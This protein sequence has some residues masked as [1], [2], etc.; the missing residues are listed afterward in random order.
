MT[1]LVKPGDVGSPIYYLFVRDSGAADVTNLVGVSAGN[2]IY[3]G[4]N[5]SQVLQLVST[6]GGNGQAIFILRGLGEGTTEVWA[7]VIAGGPTTGGVVSGGVS[8]S[9]LVTVQK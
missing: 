2:E 3:P 9:M 5:T 8:Q 6:S 4:T 1:V 7:S